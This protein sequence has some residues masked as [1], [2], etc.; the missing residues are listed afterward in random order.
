M[1]AQLSLCGQVFSFCYISG[2]SITRLYGKWT[3]N[4]SMNCPTV[5]QQWFLVLRSH[6]QYREIHFLK[7]IQA[8]TWYYPSFLFQS[9]KWDSILKS[10]DITL[11]TKVHLAKARVFPVV[12]YRCEIWTINKAEHRII[13]AFELWCWSRLLRVPWTARRSN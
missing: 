11:S 2:S 5:F 6:H 4:V 9:S 3:F 10:R 1:L 12:M 7:F 13:D 8:D